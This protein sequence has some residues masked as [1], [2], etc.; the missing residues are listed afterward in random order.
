M[1]TMRVAK[2]LEWKQGAHYQLAVVGGGPAG[3]GAALAAAR[4]GVK[5]VLLESYGFLGGVGTKSC[6]P[7]YFGFGT[8]GRQCTAGLSEEFVRRMDELGAASLMVDNRCEMPEF[9]PIAG[10]PLLAKVQMQP[11]TMKLVYRRMLAEAGVDCMLYAHVV[12]AVVEDGKMRALLVSCLEGPVLLW[13]ESFIDATGDALVLAAAG[14]GVRKY[15]REDSMHNSMF[16]FVGGV[17]PFQHE[18]NCAIYE[19]AYCEGRLPQKVWDHFGYSVQLHPGVVQIAVCYAI[20]DPLDCADMSRMDLELRENVFA[21]VD[22]L[23]RE[24]PGF[25]HC[26]LLDTAMHIGVRAGQGII[27]VDTLREEAVASGRMPEDIVAVIGSS[28]GAHA[29]SARQFMADWSRREEGFC[30]VPLGAL[31]SRDLINVLAAGRDISSDPHVIGA[32][33]MMNTCMTLGEAAG[34]TAACALEKGIPAQNVAYGDL[35][36]LLQQAGFILRP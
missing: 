22:F 7:L 25:Q 20:G 6:V 32:F 23:R 15:A 2:E 21:I 31:K 18:Y 35:L 26:Y 11:E 4:R 36:P 8:N 16:F 27:G 17:T 28:Y 19:Q 13:A 9:R 5:T 12:D 24:M 3:I 10:R 33:R 14:A 1:I 30:G 29:N 34:L